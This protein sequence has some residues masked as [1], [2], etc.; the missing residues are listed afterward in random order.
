[1]QNDLDAAKQFNSFKALNGFEEAV[2][3]VEND[4]NGFN[5]V[6]NKIK[7]LKIN[8]LVTIKYFYGFD[9]VETKGRIKKIDIKNKVISILNSQILFEDIVDI[10]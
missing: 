1:M 8:D 3:L 2:K 9:F 6:E 5:S 7:R 10:C 4:I